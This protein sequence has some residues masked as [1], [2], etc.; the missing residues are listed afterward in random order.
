YTLADLFLYPSRL[1][2][3][4]IPITEAL[5]C[6]TPIVTSDAN[7]MKELAGDAAVLV[8]PE[9]PAAI[10]EAAERVLVDRALH[11]QLSARSLAR[12]ACF[13]WQRCAQETLA[14]LEEIGATANHGVR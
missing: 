12:A 5:A 8:D 3:F 1:E 6:G 7:G 10:A 9:Q 13:S 14:I 11:R 2:A 4:P